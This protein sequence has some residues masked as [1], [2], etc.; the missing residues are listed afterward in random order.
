MA[1]HGNP[2]VL[3]PEGRAVW[4]SSTSKWEY[5]YDVK[6]YLGNTRASPESFRDVINDKVKVLQTK[7]YYPF[8]MLE[9]SGNPD[10]A[11]K[12]VWGGMIIGQGF[13]P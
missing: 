5:E 10:P 3:N 13:M 11:G 1:V 7:D 12:V 6:D 4:N 9:R 2:V 8:G